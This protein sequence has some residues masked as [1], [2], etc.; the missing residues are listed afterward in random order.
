VIALLD[1]IMMKFSNYF[2]NIIPLD[3][4]SQWSIENY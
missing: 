3:G 1:E 2:K 4:I